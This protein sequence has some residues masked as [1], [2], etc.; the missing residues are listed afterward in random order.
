MPN[1]RLVSFLDSLAYRT[2]KDLKISFLLNLFIKRSNILHVLTVLLR[3]R[4]VN[5]V[6]MIIML[7]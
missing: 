1:K 2:M 7:I 3:Y 4:N 6:K 5:G